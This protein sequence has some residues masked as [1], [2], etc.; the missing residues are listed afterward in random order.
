MAVANNVD[1][2][3]M[4]LDHLGKPSITDLNEGSVEAQ[5]CL[6]QYDISRRMCLARSP[7][8]FARRLRRLSLLTANDLSDVW[9]YHYDLPNESVKLHRLVEDGRMAR[10][11]TVPAPMYLES[12]TVYTNVQTAW[13]LYSWDS[14]E[15]QSWSVLFDD[16]VAL[17]LAMRM[18]PSMTRRKTDT[19]ELQNMYREALAEAIEH[20]AQQETSSYVYHDGGYADARDSGSLPMYQQP[21]GS[22]IWE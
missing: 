8:T 17:F 15:V 16:V 20:D 19:K 22:T 12:G 11:N 9:S 10:A 5:T 21:D 7:W 3:N 13:A 14:T 18:A 4:A 6:R 1:I 2:C